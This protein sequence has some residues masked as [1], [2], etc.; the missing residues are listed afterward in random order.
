MAEVLNR[1]ERATRDFSGVDADVA[2]WLT[3]NIQRFRAPPVFAIRPPLDGYSTGI[4]QPPK[5][6]I[7]RKLPV[8]RIQRRLRSQFGQKM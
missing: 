3:S 5:L 6:T 7:L 8:Q 1:G 4:S 2:M